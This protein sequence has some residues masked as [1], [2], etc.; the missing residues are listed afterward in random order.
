MH[1]GELKK[2]VIGLNP[3]NELKEYS[4]EVVVLIAKLSEKLCEFH[5]ENTLI[6][7][8]MR[9]L[10]EELINEFWSWGV[11]NLPIGQWPN[12]VEVAPWLAL[13]KSLYEARL[14][15]IDFHHPILYRELYSRYLSLG[16]EQLN[17][18][19]IILLLTKIGRRLGYADKK[20]VADIMSLLTKASQGLGHIEEKEL[21]Y[22]PAQQLKKRITEKLHQEI[23]KTEDIIYFIRAAFYLIYHYCTTEQLELLPYLIYFRAKTT[24]EERRSELAIFIWLQQNP[25]TCLNFFV[26]SQKYLNS[27]SRTEISSIRN[28]PKHSDLIMQTKDTHWVYLFIH[29]T[30][31]R[32]DNEQIDLINDTLGLIETDFSTRKDQSFNAAMDFSNQVKKQIDTLPLNEARTVY[33]ANAFFGLTK[34]EQDRSADPREKHSAFSLS[35]KTKLKA[36]EKK[37]LQILG[38]NVQFSFFEELALNQGRVKK[39]VEPHK[40]KQMEIFSL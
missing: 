15:N 33:F 35:G 29:L 26:E 22:Y 8:S 18:D 34:Y 1:V 12:S 16:D 21:D 11:N 25:K 36:V 17:A 30:R 14:L 27:K 13:E 20:E 5:D 28:L 4:Q 31:T 19:E 24:D 3:Q 9:P 2:L 10:I 7:D 39:I 38:Q 6:P 23:V 32:S 37:K 40:H